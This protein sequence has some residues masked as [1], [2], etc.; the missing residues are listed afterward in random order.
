MKRRVGLVVVGQVVTVVDAHVPDD[1]EV[2][3]EVI[4]D[5]TWNLQTGERPP[6]FAVLHQRCVDYLTEHK[7][8]SVVVKASALTTGP[9]KLAL[10]ESAEVRGVVMAA[11]ATAGCSVEVL[12][13]QT[14]SRTYGDRKVDEYLKDDAFWN[15]R[16]AGQKLRK[17]SREAA[18]L[19]IA[20]RS[21]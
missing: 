9:A 3:I 13:K 2:P 15:D 16:A 10:L 11:S 12:S 1:K 20:A 17:T 14:V 18:M 21:R 8:G 5:A 4:M 7:I 19:L 6:A